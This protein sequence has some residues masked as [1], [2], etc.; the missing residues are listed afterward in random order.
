MRK[1]VLTPKVSQLSIRQDDE[2]VRKKTRE[3]AFA[4]VVPLVSWQPNSSPVLGEGEF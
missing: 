1:A 3:V 2:C 4:T